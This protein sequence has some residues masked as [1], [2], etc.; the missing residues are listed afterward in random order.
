MII[1]LS[2]IKKIRNK[3]GITQKELSAKAGVSQ[4]LIAKIESGMIDPTYS[5][6]NK[7]INAL[8]ELSQKSEKC[9]DTIMNKKIAS[10]KSGD[11]IKDAVKKM[12]NFGV[13]QIPIIENNTCIG[14][15]SESDILQSIMSKK[16]KL[17]KDIMEDCP[18]IITKKTKLSVV[19]ELLK[20]YSLVL[21]GE[22]GK[23][24]GL[25]TKSD[26]LSEL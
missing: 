13:S 15:V 4:S 25:V 19:S 23:L 3:I 21:I 22:S 5:K 8:E 6:A 17:L 24:I 9:V 1:N 2:E 20:Y 16:D 18:P 26:L 7:I 14:I 11:T 12:K 10:C